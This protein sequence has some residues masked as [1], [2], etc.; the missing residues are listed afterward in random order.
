MK[1]EDEIIQNCISILKK[2]LSPKKIILFGSRAKGSAY[3]G[4]DFDFA[5]DKSPSSAQLETL[6]RDKLERAAGLHKVDLI[7]MD[8]VDPK[9][10]EI[11]LKTG[12]VLYGK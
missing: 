2:E 9:F 11:I 8:A 4:S 5:V 1:R 7:F 3:Q 12:K 6:V 10:K